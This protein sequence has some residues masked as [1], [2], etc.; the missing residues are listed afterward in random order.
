MRVFVLATGASS[1]DIPEGVAT[2]Y[3]DDEETHKETIAS[4][5]GPIPTELDEGSL[6]KSANAD[7][8]ASVMEPASRW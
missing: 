2:F 3:V 7:I 4:K 5:S 8:P 6:A 1:E